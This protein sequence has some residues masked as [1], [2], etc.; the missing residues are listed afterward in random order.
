MGFEEKIAAAILFVWPIIPVFWLP[1]HILCTILKAPPKILP[2][3]VAGVLYLPIFFFI[4]QNLGLFLK[5]T[6]DIPGL[7]KALGWILFALG[8]LIHAWTIYPHSP[9]GKGTKKALWPGLRG[10]CSKNPKDIGV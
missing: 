8:I 1:T 3:L 6:V 10:I 2:Y 5:W 9:G 4:E 7:V